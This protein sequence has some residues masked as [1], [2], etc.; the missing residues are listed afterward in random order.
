VDTLLGLF[1]EGCYA[2]NDDQSL[3]EALLQRK[4]LSN[5]GFGNV[6]SLEG[7]FHLVPNQ[8]KR[9]ILV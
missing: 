8:L 3:V 2:W 4:L 9:T 5:D 6:Q 7:P 1:E